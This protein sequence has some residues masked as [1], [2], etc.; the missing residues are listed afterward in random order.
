MCPGGEIQK[1]TVENTT[2]T[3]CGHKPYTQVTCTLIASN[4]AGNSPDKTVE[5]TTFCGGK[6]YFTVKLQPP[7]F[8]TF[9]YIQFLH[10][11]G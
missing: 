10:V 6:F 1:D 2:V 9:H 3:S 8:V 11:L 4:N 5:A 7:T